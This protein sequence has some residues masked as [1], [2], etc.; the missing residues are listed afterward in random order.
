MKDSDLHIYAQ[1]HSHQDAYIVGNREAL[2][3]L[4]EAIEM[5]LISKKDG[6]FGMDAFTSDG[7]GYKIIVVETDDMEHM[8]LPY[9]GDDFHVARGD[10]SDKWPFELIG[11]EKYRKLFGK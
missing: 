11:K 5:V 6:V 10:G 8:V 4:K 7:E 2:I 3:A 9:T 1:A